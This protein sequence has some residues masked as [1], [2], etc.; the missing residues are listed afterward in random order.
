MIFLDNPNNPTGTSIEKE[1]F[2]L[3][4]EQLPEDIIVV[5][6]EA[7]VDFMAR[8]RHI[9]VQGY[10]R[11]GKPLAALRTFSKAYGLSGLRLGYG[12]MGVE[13]AGYINRVRQPFNVN[14]LAQV[15]GLAALADDEHYRMT[16]Q[17]SHDGIAWLSQEVAKLGCRPMGTQTNF[18][19]IDVK[20]D[21]RKLYEH[22]LHQGVIVRPMQAYGYPNYIRITVGRAAENKRFVESLAKSLKELGYG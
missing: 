20:G 16:L 1:D 10:I 22:M 12:I 4:M 11:D 5:L 18:F 2:A 14:S 17:K 19:L 21:G 9:D 13:M 3:F 8:E 7:Y 15:G 6:D